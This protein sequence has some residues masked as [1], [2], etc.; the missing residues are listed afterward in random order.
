MIRIFFAFVF[1]LSPKLRGLYKRREKMAKLN[2]VCC[3]DWEVIGW[4]WCTCRKCGK[5]EQHEDIAS[6]YWTSK[7]NRMYGDTPEIITPDMDK[8][9]KLKGVHFK[10]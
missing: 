9:L 6:A 8:K 5:R 7:F 10:R 4:T 1:S 3:H 2:S